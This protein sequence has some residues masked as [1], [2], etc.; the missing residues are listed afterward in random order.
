MTN[1]T[2]HTAPA[3]LKGIL[4]DQHVLYMK[5]RNYHW[6]V[7]GQNFYGLHAAFEKLYDELAEDIDAVAERI[8]ILGVKAPGTMKELLE[9]ASLKEEQPAT[10]P[11]ARSMVQNLVNDLDALTK[12]IL[13]AASAVQRDD[14]DEVSASMLYELAEKHQKTA[15]MLRSTLES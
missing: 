13:S 14:A 8:R 3:L 5:A 12:T 6:N 7:V 4:A 15:W 11:D 2:K 10:Y 1:G 9:L